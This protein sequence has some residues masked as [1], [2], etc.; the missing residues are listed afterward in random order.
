SSVTRE[1]DDDVFSDRIHREAHDRIVAVGEGATRHGK[2]HV[3]TAPPQEEEKRPADHSDLCSPG[4]A[5]RSQSSLTRRKVTAP[6]TRAWPAAGGP[7]TR[8][9][10]N[11][12]SAR[13]P[14]DEPS[15]PTCFSAAI[16]GVPAPGAKPS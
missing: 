15:V 8:S 3:P 1:S 11:I 16:T 7:S 13:L 4:N 12:A 9:S 5:N 6:A 14:D 2:R 10:R